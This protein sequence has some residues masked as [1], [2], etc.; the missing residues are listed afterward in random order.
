[1][2]PITAVVEEAEVYKI[3]QLFNKKPPGLTFNETDALVIKARL[4][5]G[6]QIGATFYFTLK[7]DGTFEEEALGRDAVKAR[8][9]KLASF[10]RYYRLADEVDKYK[11]KERIHELKGRGVEVI[12]I[13]GELSIY[14]PYTPQVTTHDR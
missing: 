8:R 9:H 14:T 10:L 6:R 13:H 1:M 4:Q 2:Q 11:L 7:P 5:D 3:S 12:P